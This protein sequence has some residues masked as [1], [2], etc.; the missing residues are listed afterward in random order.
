MNLL[1]IQFVIVSLKEDMFNN[2]NVLFKTR[3][4]DGSSCV[5]RTAKK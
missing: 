5:S 2:A 3:F 1:A 4:F